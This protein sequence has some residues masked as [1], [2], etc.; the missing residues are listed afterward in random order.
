MQKL[1]AV[2]ATQSMEVLFAV[3]GELLLLKSV[4]PSALSWS[5]MALVMIGMVLQSHFSNKTVKRKIHNVSV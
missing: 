1:A 4:M 3:M 2:E 5:G